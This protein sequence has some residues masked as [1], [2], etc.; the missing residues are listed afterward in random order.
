MNDTALLLCLRHL[1]EAES[2]MVEGVDGWHLARLS[3]VIEGLKEAYA[4]HPPAS[5]VT[6]ST[7]Q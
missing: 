7:I 6:V 1:E 5:L 2:L 3:H 4:L